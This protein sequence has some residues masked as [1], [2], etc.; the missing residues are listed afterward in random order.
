M[1]RALFAAP[2]L[3]LAAFGAA[4]CQSEPDINPSPGMADPI[5]APYNDPQIAVLAPELREGIGFHPAIVVDDG[6]HPMDVTVPV[7]N[8]TNQQYHLQYRFIFYDEYGRE[9]EP[10]MGWD[11]AFMERKQTQRWNA[12]ALSTDAKSYRLEVKWAR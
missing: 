11:R 9:L 2:M 7:R 1:N 12:N 8:L 4:G 6:E 3:A 10:V 5:G